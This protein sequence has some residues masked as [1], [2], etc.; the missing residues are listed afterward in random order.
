MTLGAEESK[1]KDE[2][3]DKDDGEGENNSTFE[4]EKTDERFYEQT[5][6]NLPS[7]Q[8]PTTL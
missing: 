5:S 8:P 2:E 7:F 3:S 6:M 1:D 4:A